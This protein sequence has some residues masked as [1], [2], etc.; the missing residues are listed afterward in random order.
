MQS[1]YARTV[2]FLFLVICCAGCVSL[3]KIVENPLSPN[4]Q[5]FPSN[6]ENVNS[7]PGMSTGNNSPPSVV[8]IRFR[9]SGKSILAELG[10]STDSEN[11]VTFDKNEV[12]EKGTCILSL[13]YENGTE[14]PYALELQSDDYS[15]LNPPSFALQ[16][17][18]NVLIALTQDEVLEKCVF[19]YAAHDHTYMS[20]YTTTFQKIC[21]DTEARF[22][23]AIGYPLMPPYAL[24]WESQRY[25]S[26]EY[27]GSNVI[28]LSKQNVFG[29]DVTVI[30][31]MTH[32]VMQKAH[33][34]TWFNE[35]IAD[36]F[37]Y[38][39]YGR[40]HL[41]A[42]YFEGMETWE[43]VDLTNTTI[44]TSA[45]NAAHYSVAQFVKKYGREKLQVL[46]DYYLENPFSIPKTTK[47]K[48][49]NSEKLLKKM[50]EITGD[51]ALISIPVLMGK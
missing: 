15:I 2:L 36:Y 31:E 35:G 46:M 6:D 22:E 30:H 45:Y 41:P 17:P 51:E 8:H 13:H 42:P 40:V 12:C 9:E 10:E 11:T 49:E 44:S 18:A 34:P 50:R 4:G 43:T 5:D 26:G 37:A 24:V 7:S 20:Q 14:F 47:E 19:R 39:Y 32:A 38:E 33:F 23:A 48:L 28:F 27:S 29:L 21:N 25:S 3:N 1:V 16:G